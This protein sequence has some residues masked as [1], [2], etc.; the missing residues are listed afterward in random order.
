MRTA[1]CFGEY[2]LV[3]FLSVHRLISDSFKLTAFGKAKVIQAKLTRVPTLRC[4]SPRLYCCT[5]LTKRRHFHLTRCWRG[6]CLYGLRGL[7]SIQQT[8]TLS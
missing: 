6:L 7:L 3:F 2:V 4:V 8:A 1:R 5:M